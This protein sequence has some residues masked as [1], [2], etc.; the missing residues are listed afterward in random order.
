MER[1]EMGS[2]AAL[3]NLP[4]P[5]DQTWQAFWQEIEELLVKNREDPTRVEKLASNR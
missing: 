2:P 4:E 1:D 3:A 5:E